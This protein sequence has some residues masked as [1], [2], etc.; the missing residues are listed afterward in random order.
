MNSEDLV[1]RCKWIL[2]IEHK[3]EYLRKTE[4]EISIFKW[5]KTGCYR[6]RR[7]PSLN[8]KTQKSLN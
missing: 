2:L 1:S 4:A 6:N 7:H 8:Y 3:N 5:I